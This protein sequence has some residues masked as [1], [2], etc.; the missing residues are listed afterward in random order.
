MADELRAAG[1]AESDGFDKYL[2]ARGDEIRSLNVG[3]FLIWCGGW[4]GKSGGHAI[5]YIIDR[6][7]E[8]AVSFVVCN[9]GSGVGYHPGTAEGY[10]K[11]KRF[12]SMRLDGVAMERVTHSAWL[13]LLFRINA[14]GDED[15]T[16]EMFYNVVLPALTGKSLVAA[17][18]ASGEDSFAV[19]ETLQVGVY[20]CHIQF[21]VYLQ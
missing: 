5:M 6:T 16:P 1:G 3:D 4:S 8:D 19:P 15:H 18:E 17:V 11:T 21:T 10:P 2:A 12:T 20:I 9:T 14:F 7:A 13:Y